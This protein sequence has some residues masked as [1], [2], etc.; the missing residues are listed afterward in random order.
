V[1]GP[2]PTLRKAPAPSRAARHHDEVNGCADILTSSI[3]FIALAQR[4]QTSRSDDLIAEMTK[5]PRYPWGVAQ[6]K[7]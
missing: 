2:M 6:S 5:E 3:T 1:D 7:I 4:I